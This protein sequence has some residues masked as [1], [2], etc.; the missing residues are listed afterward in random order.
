MPLVEMN[1]GC[2]KDQCT[3]VPI[4]HKPHPSTKSKN[5]PSMADQ[6]PRNNK[7]PMTQSEEVESCGKGDL[8]ARPLLRGGSSRGRGDLYRTPVGARGDSD[9]KN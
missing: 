8:G 4:S 5:P 3:E 9:P 6:N 1:I 7:A 2:I